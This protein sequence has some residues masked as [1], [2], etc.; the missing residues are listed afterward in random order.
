MANGSKNLV[1]HLTGFNL[2]TMVLARL[3]ITE[4]MLA[5]VSV[6][7]ALLLGVVTFALL[8][9]E[10]FFSNEDGLTTLWDA[11]TALLAVDIVALGILVIL[12]SRQIFRLIRDR[13][14]RLAGYQ[15]HWRLGTLFGVITVF[16][17]I[18]VV[19]F[20]FFVLDIS[21][22]GWF[23]ER[24]KTAITESV[25][26]A[27]SYLEEH[28][29][30]ARGQI[31]AMANDINREAGSLL[32]D[33]RRFEAFL[34]HQAGLR[35]LSE[36]VVIDST[37]RV[38]AN[39][40]FA[41]S[42]TFSSLDEEFF[43]KARAGEVA[44]IRPDVTNRVRA[45][46]RLDQFVDGYLL[47]GRFV[48]PNVSD[49]VAQT[50]LAASEYQLLDLRQLGLKVS[51][52]L[53]FGMV[54]LLLLLG[55]IWVGLN[56]ANAI[57]EPISSII[58]VAE[59]VGSGNL[60]SRVP[61]SERSDEIARLGVSFNRMLDDIN[62]NREQLV[63]ANRQLDKRREFTEAVLGGV[64]SGV[65]GIDEFRRITLPN[66]AALEM[67]GLDKLECIGKKLDELVPEF[68]VLLDSAEADGGTQE[69][70]LEIK[71]DETTL[72]LRARVTTETVAKSIVGYVVTFENVS[73]LLDA[74]RKAAWTDVA[75]SIAHEIKNP[76]TPI[77][78]AAERLR[79][80]YMPA[81]EEE[82]NKA[83]S[84]IDTIIRQVNDIGRMVNE[85][86]AFARLP[87][88]DLKEHD[89]VEILVGQVN[90]FEASAN[91]K[92]TLDLGGENEVMVICDVGMMRQTI[93]NILQNA[94]E[95][96]EKTKKS[97]KRI[98]ITL[99]AEGDKVTLAIYDNGIGLPADR[100][101][102]L[103]TP[104]VTFR[105]GG[106]GLGLSIV[107]KIADDH[108]GSLTLEPSENPKYKG[109]AVSLTLPKNQGDA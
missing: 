12:V 58:L 100:G 19:V 63:E 57:V 80:K 34:T 22:R 68:G 60:R 99:N 108:S 8:S 93:T 89:L 96:M 70:N 73:A 59:Q 38:L 87:K 39:S 92:I 45:G 24:I 36:A 43:A 14:R 10:S 9:S 85:F 3:K 51:F 37:G 50:K 98:L 69:Q 44:I 17:A 11:T 21:L 90:L 78:L 82:R 102:D 104:Y 31:L 41:Y 49:A 27:D 86:S 88:P 47:V 18:I 107:Q 77:H 84:Y 1:A 81:N 56:F 65:I 55:S 7:V 66:R 2:A 75:R 71:K 33:R 42:V 40:R 62:K 95:A 61:S 15:L 16:P 29:Q 79:A 4:Q 32:G 48:D 30:S 105:K 54:S 6:G 67:L 74:Q 91:T 53:L 103:T 20:S 97:A 76:L 52:A 25:T 46:V 35:N 26:V 106:T 83:E 64:S 101:I 72:T 28:V 23:N 5:Y 94:V 109:A 13:R